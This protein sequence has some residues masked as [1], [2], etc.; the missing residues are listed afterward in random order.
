MSILI[1]EIFG[2]TI[3]GE[4]A[5]IGRPTVFVRTGGCDFRCNWCI[6]PETSILMADLS[7]KPAGEICIGDRVIGMQRRPSV[8]EV[9]GPY[10]V[11]EVL[12]VTRRKAPRYA[13]EMEDGRELIVAADHAFVAHRTGRF[14]SASQLS[15]STLLRGL[16]RWEQWSETPDYRAGYLAGAAD[17][18]G[19]F[20]FKK[21]GRVFNFV[22][23]T[24]DDEILQRFARYACSFGFALNAGTHLSGGQ[25]APSRYIGCYRLTTTQRVHEFQQFLSNYPPSLNFWR[26]YFAGIYDT[27]GSTDGHTLRIAQIKEKFKARIESCLNALALDWVREEKGYRLRG[28]RFAARRLLLETRPALDRKVRPFFESLSGHQEPLRPRHVRPLAEGEVVSIR[29][30]LGTYIAEGLLSRN[31]DTLYAVLPQHKG[32]WAKMD[33]PAI[34]SEVEKLSGSAPILITLSGGNPALQPLGEL[35]ELGHARG[36]TFAL[37]TQASQAPA[38]LGELDHLVLSPKP[39]SSKMEFSEPQLARCLE[40]ARAGSHQP[41]ISIKVVVFDEADFQFA[42]RVYDSHSDV[43]FYLSIGN[44]SVMSGAQADNSALTRQLEWLLE[45]CA[46]ENW[47]DVTLTPQLHVLLWGNKRGV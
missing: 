37:E 16:A 25:F 42:R 19:S 4:G 1:S 23:A 6:A 12:G 33:A 14:I 35:L 28:A 38:W 15:D 26:G 8:P 18:D 13:L 45:R 10:A 7:S 29:T 31:C 5:L 41:H 27:D 2:P 40:V 17:G 32:D 36:Y 46:Q 44:A 3:Q 22:I 47:F 24:G 30:S 34:L 43:P 21:V 20:H 11:G 9:V 39:P